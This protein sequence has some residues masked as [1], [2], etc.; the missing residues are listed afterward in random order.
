MVEFHLRAEVGTS[1]IHGRNGESA[2]QGDEKHG[3]GQDH[4]GCGFQSGV[5]VGAGE[6]QPDH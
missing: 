2:T 4:H 3:S 5:S 6:L 1:G